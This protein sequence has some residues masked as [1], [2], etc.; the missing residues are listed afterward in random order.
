M[1][2]DR[3][4][5]AREISLPPDSHKHISATLSSYRVRNG[6]LHNPAND[7]RTTEGVFHI[8]EGGL[9]IPLDKKAVP[10]V[11]FARFY[12]AAFNP[13]PAMLELPFTAGEVEKARTMV[14][15]LLRPVVRPEVPGYCEERSMEIRFF[16]PGSL[17]PNLDFVESIFGNS[18]DPFIPENDAALDPIHWTGTSGCIILA[19]HLTTFTKKDLGLPHWV[20]EGTH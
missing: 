19:P 17:S 4:G 1:V 5:M 3:Y 16:A 20:L 14:S 12:E 15:L 2:L 9:P 13:P 11:V 6:V 8:T 10:K 7:K 18:G